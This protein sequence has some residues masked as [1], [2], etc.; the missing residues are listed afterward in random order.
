MMLKKA[1]EKQ[2]MLRRVQVQRRKVA[3]RMR[4]F[5]MEAIPS[6]DDSGNALIPNHKLLSLLA[7]RKKFLHPLSLMRKDECLELGP[8]LPSPLLASEQST[9][10]PITRTV[11][12]AGTASVDA[13]P[14][15]LMG[16]G[17]K[18]TR[19]SARGACRR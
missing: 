15:D 11:R 12:G 3:V 5:K 13:V 2:S 10:S 4:R 9:T 16:R 19:N 14:R 18:K 8:I 1:Q 7:P 6:D 17:L